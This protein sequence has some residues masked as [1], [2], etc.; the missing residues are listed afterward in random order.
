MD[1]YSY[2]KERNKKKKGEG[3]KNMAK[4]LV[5]KSDIMLSSGVIY[6]YVSTNFLT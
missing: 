3:D 4:K 6:P 1:S 5:L 2:K